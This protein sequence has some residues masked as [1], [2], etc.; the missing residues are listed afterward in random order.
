MGGVF[1][2]I[3]S[4]IVCAK[5]DGV[6]QI[7]LEKHSQNDKSLRQ[8]L[9]EKNSNYH[10]VFFFFAFLYVD[11]L[12]AAQGVGSIFPMAFYFYEVQYLRV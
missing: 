11:N 3:S 7:C 9:F 1:A 4:A 2:A 10:W 12:W 5:H 8:C 6:S